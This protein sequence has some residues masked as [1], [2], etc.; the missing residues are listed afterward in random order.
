MDTFWC[1]QQQELRR[2]VINICPVWAAW[3]RISRTNCS[4]FPKYPPARGPGCSTAIHCVAPS[5]WQTGCTF[6]EN[7]IILPLFTSFLFPPLLSPALLIGA[8][9]KGADTHKNN[10]AQWG[11]GWRSLNC[12]NWNPP[13]RSGQKGERPCQPPVRAGKLKNKIVRL[14][15]SAENPSGK[16]CVT[17]RESGCSQDAEGAV[18]CGSCW[19]N[20]GRE[21]VRC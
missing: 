17:V 11:R 18:A 8:G 16:P 12:S 20:Q 14:Q 5:V 10:A 4:W 6:A 21:N 15:N 7:W 9:L 2:V 3:P 13:R 1:L 19:E